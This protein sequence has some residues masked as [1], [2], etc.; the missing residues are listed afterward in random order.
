MH[1]T[2]EVCGMEFHIPTAALQRAHMLLS[3]G[4][5]MLANAH[6]AVRYLALNGIPKQTAMYALGVEHLP[7]G[8]IG[9]NDGIISGKQTVGG[10]HA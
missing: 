6:H 5:D 4:T 10:N 2:V 9:V 1:T 7:I 8:H 3:L